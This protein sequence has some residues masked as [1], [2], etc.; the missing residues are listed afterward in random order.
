MSKIINWMFTTILL[1]G[2][3]MCGLTSCDDDNEETVDEFNLVWNL[4]MVETGSFSERDLEYLERELNDRYTTEKMTVSQAK[5]ATE[6]A[7]QRI[8]KIIKDNQWYTMGCKYYVY[9]KLYDSKEKLVTS[10]TITVINN[11]VAYK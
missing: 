3:V 7:T 2:T 1:C 11:Q 8:V 4:E 10:K 9:V 6:N 5:T